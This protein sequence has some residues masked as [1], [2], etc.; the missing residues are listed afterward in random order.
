MNIG[1]D[2]KEKKKIRNFWQLHILK[3]KE[4]LNQYMNL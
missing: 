2:V 4:H 3:F 1:R